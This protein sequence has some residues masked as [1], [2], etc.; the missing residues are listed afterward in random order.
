MKKRTLLVLLVAVFLML[1]GAALFL[2]PIF[3]QNTVAKPTVYTVNA[4]FQHIEIDLDKTD[5]AICLDDKTYIEING[6]RESEYFISAEDGKLLLTDRSEKS[7]LLFKLSGIGKMIKESHQISDQK[8]IVLHLS[9]LH[10]QTPVSIILKNSKLTLSAPLPYLTLHAENSSVTAKDMTFE[11]FNGKLINCNSLFSFPYS[12]NGFSR[13][14]ETHNTVFSINGD[15]RA[16]TEKFVTDFQ[17]PSMI[18][19]ALGGTCRLEY[20]QDTP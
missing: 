2:F 3:T 15:E 18:I 16:N 19:E 11:R 1:V 14:I 7:P 17:K 5:F 9:P 20:P 4:D 12:A 6:Y 13:N 8:S 10:L